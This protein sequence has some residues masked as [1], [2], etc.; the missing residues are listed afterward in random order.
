MVELRK[1]LRT[2]EAEFAKNLTIKLAEYAKGRKL[3]RSDLEVVDQVVADSASDGY[4]FKSL[5][6]RMLMSKLM[7]ER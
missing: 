7:L 6:L 5:L 1:I 3:N 4:R 2:R